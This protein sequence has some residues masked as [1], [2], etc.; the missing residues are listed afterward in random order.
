MKKIDQRVTQRF[1]VAAGIL[2]TR[3]FSADPSP[4]PRR[5]AF[6]CGP[7]SN[8]PAISRAHP[9]FDVL[10]MGFRPGKEWKGPSEVF[11]EEMRDGTLRTWDDC[12]FWAHDHEG[13]LYLLTDDRDVCFSYD[14]NALVIL[15]G[16][17]DGR[18]E[19]IRRARVRLL[20]AARRV[21]ANIAH[22]RMM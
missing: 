15:G 10:G 6:A 3:V 9:T 20:E 13:P 18:E 8:G 16:D 5:L 22:Q 2:M 4:N 7:A 19:G 12:Q 14:G 1:A 21:P 11:V 17:P